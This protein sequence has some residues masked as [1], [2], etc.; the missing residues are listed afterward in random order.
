MQMNRIKRNEHSLAMLW[1]GCRIDPIS[2]GIKN[3]AISLKKCLNDDYAKM[4]QRL[5]KGFQLNHH[6]EFDRI[7]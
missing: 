6:F 1:F 4:I 5:D 2:M 3:K 7:E